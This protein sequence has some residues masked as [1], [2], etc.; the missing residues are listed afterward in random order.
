M[1]SG[2]FKMHTLAP[3]YSHDINIEA[4]LFGI[5]DSSKPTILSYSVTVPNWFRVTPSQTLFRE[6]VDWVFGSRATQAVLIIP[7]L[8]QFTASSVFLFSI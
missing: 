6:C 5:T 1:S 8:L 3:F 2:I 4:F 7:F